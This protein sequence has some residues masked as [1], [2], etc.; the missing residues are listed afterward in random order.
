MAKSFYHR[1]VKQDVTISEK[2][3]AGKS[4]AVVKSTFRN[5]IRYSVSF[6][7]NDL[8]NLSNFETD[9]VTMEL[10]TF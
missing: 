4:T 10:V 9:E 3:E 7:T 1:D 2:H 5:A 8:K 6:T